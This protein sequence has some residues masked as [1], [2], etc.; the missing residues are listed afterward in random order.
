MI[1]FE[2]QEHTGLART[3]RIQTTRGHI[4]TPVF[5]PVG[6]LGT[7][8]AMTPEELREVG[9]SIILGNAYHLHLRPGDEVVRQ[10]GGLHQFMGWPYPILTDSGGFQVFSL[11]KLRK[12]SEEGVVFQNH[13]NGNAILL[14][15]EKSIAIQENLGSD[16][17]MCFDECLRLPASYA[18]IE[19]SI[20]LTSSWAKRCKDARKTNH[21]LFGIV[22]GGLH[23]DLRKRSLQELL[24]IGFDGYAI[25]G[26]SVGESKDEMYGILETI[27]P[28]LPERQ[29][30][31]VMG[32]GDPEDLLEAIDH[33]IDMFDCVLPTRNAR[34][35]CLF[36]SRGKISV[37][38]AQYREDSLPA[39]PDC[40][41]YVC[42]HYSRAYLRHLYISKEILSVRLNTYHNLYFYLNLVKKARVAIENKQ[43]AGFK[44]S[45]LEKYNPV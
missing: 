20:S 32:I 21:A 18:E 29:P 30:R 16:I 33:G 15:P 8:K 4:S 40:A 22:Q 31:Y 17:M 13:L 38:Q 44:Q 6:T 27:T 26:L 37:K 5:M 41:C 9:V 2:Q 34:N 42:R 19:K 3:G 45:F 35:G 1:S 11:A 23:L 36:T 12:L 39:D 24:E 43:F 28:L 10:L 7:V 25:G 14:T